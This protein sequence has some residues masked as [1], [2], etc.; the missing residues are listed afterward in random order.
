[1]GRLVQVSMAC[2]ALISSGCSAGSVSTQPTRSPGATIF[3]KV[4]TEKTSGS[5]SASSC[6]VGT[7]SPSKR[8]MP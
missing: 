3:E 2:L 5:P 4:R 8:S 6:R 1:M 7:G